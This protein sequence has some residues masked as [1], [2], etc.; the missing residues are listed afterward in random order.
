MI[1]SNMMNTIN[2]PPGPRPPGPPIDTIVPF[3]LFLPHLANSGEKNIL[4]KPG[5]GREEQPMTCNS[6]PDGDLKK[7]IIGVV[8]RF[9]WSLL[10]GASGRSGQDDD[11]KD[12][13]KDDDDTPPPPPPSPPTPG[14][15]YPC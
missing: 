8:I 10:S 15:P 12:D 1:S 3:P 13:E 9:I 4:G 7:V 2:C 14:P 11:E 6:G 5:D